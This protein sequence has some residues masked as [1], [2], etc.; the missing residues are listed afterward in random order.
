VSLTGALTLDA[1]SVY[2][3]QATGAKYLIKP[4]D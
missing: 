3:A 2:G 4:N 1:I